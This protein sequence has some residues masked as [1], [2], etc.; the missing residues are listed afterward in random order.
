MMLLII[1]GLVDARSVLDGVSLSMLSR[2]AG[3]GLNLRLMLVDRLVDLGR[4]PHQ[5]AGPDVGVLRNQ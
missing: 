5:L 2:V 4:F 3:L 1:I